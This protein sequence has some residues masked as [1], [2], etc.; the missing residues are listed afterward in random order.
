MRRKEILKAPVKKPEL[1]EEKQITAQIAGNYLVLDIWK[2]KTCNIRHAMEVHTGEYGTYYT[3]GEKWTGE[4]LNNAVDMGEYWCGGCS[5]SEYHISKKDKK[6]IEQATEGYSWCGGDIYDRIE[7]KERE[8]SRE[9]AET[10]RENKY[11]RLRNLMDICQN[12]GPKVKEWIADVATGDMQYAFYDKQSSRYHCTACNSDFQQAAGIRMKHKD[13]TTCPLCGHAIIA[14]KRGTARKSM[15]TALTIIENMDEKRGVERYFRVSIEWEKTREVFLEEHIRLLMLRDQRSPFKIYYDGGWGNWGESNR[16]NRRWETGYLYPDEQKIREGLERT[17]YGVWKEVLPMLAQ[18]GIE[19][20]YN[21]L[22]VE[23][24]KYF[25]RITEYLFKGR[26]YRL[27]RETSE[28]I[29]P[30]YGYSN[31]EP[32]RIQEESIEGVM[33]I[34]DRQKINRLRQENGGEIMLEWLQWADKRKRKISTEC[35]KW[36]EKISYWPHDFQKSEASKYLNLEKL[37]NYI[38]RQKNESYKG[39]KESTILNQYDDYLDMAKNLGKHMDDEMVYRPRELKRRHDELVKEYELR[40]KEMQRKLD[41]EAAERKAERM[42][43]KYPGYEEIL[44]EVKQKYEYENDTYLIRVP[45]N[46][47]EITAEG[48]ALHHCVGN[49]ERYFDRIVSRETYICFLRQQSSPE[50]PYYTIEVEPGGTI[51]QHR[52]AYD[53]EPGIEEIKP[54]MREWQKVIRKRM[55]HA[56]HE[57]AKKSEILRQK[58][59]DELREKNN[60]RVLEGLMED[61]MEVI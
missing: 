60:T 11:R 42:R 37:M 15:R 40:R 10:K 14:I 27:L 18:A 1:K 61:L 17:A 2:N 41:K 46:F 39:K 16:A 49:T 13:Q 36:L 8:Y 9:L 53:E 48:M 52:G 6:I 35:L 44:Q 45:E 59:I 30:Y 55:S 26:F 50:T 31:S 7:Y 34:H 58:N 4:N 33:Q 24:N 3:D 19:A 54:F 21:G 12:P 22:L 23:S 29:S 47:A 20:N 38:I 28:S 25:T 5:E 57:F 32:L 51:R 43:Q 56:D